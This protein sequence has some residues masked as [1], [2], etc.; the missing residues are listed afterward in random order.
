[1]I[2]APEQ[3]RRELR[4]GRT[5]K[6][7]AALCLKLRPD[8]ERIDEPAQAAKLALRSLA[9]RIREL[10]SEILELDRQLERLVN[11]AAPRTVQLFGVGTR[12][13]ANSSSPR[14]KTSS[15]SATKLRSRRSAAPPRS[16]QARA[17]R[18]ATDSTSAATD[19]PTGHS[20]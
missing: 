14:G 3:L 11:A 12:A 19:K 10:D 15:G 17:A 13:Q 4:S 20:T 7:R 8:S 6:A 2:T 9:R 18:N 5:L 16:K 1:M